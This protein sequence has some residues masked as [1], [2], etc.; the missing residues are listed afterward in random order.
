MSTI[1]KTQATG[2]SW[3]GLNKVCV[4]KGVLDLTGSAVTENDDYTLID[5]PAG[6]LVL[7][8]GY[9]IVTAAVG[10]T[11]TID[12]GY[13]GNGQA[14]VDDFGSNIDGKGTAGTIGYTAS[15]TADGTF[16]SAADTIDVNFDVATAITAGPKM[17]VYAVCVKVTD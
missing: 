17:N 13:G 2:P 12:I 9:K 3:D 5:I 8:C 1:D 11:C 14:T 7:G 15:A 16:F 10:T 4:L 6:Y